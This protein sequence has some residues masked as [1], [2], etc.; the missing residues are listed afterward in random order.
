MADVNNI[1]L[2]D[3]KNSI[4]RDDVSAL[5]FVNLAPLD[6]TQ[7]EAF[8]HASQIRMMS[9]LCL[10]AIPTENLGAWK[11]LF[12]NYV[13]AVYQANKSG[14]VPTT[15]RSIRNFSESFGN[16][17]QVDM[18]AFYCDNSDLIGMFSRC[19]DGVG[20]QSRYWQNE[21]WPDGI[22]PGDMLPDWPAGRPF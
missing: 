10:D 7:A 11:M 22:R 6:D 9:A 5:A 16:D 4:T 20:F 18:K 17:G 13:A 8:I 14:I 19:S 2:D 3:V 21:D 12:A 1:N 15:A